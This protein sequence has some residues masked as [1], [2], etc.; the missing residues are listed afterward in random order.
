MVQRDRDGRGRLHAALTEA[1]AVAASARQALQ[2]T[3]RRMIEERRQLDDTERRG[4]QADQIGDSETV[5]IAR[6]F[7][8]R[9]R[10]RLSLLERRLE[11]EGD[12]LA[13]A[14]AVAAEI[15]EQ[16]GGD[17]GPVDVPDARPAPDDGIPKH[18]YDRAAHEAAAEAQLAFLKKKMGK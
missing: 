4:R 15:A 7:A 17:A 14:Q 16:A 8:A 12:E 5:A 10:E 3:E 18:R 13:L 6:K 9:H 11:L 1:K 2:L